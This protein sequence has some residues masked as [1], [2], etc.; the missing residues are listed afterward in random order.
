M[1]VIFL[2]SSTATFK[3][4]WMIK[5]IH[6]KKEVKNYLKLKKKI[7]IYCS[8]MSLKCIL[9]AYCINIYIFLQIYFVIVLSHSNKKHDKWTYHVF[10]ISFFRLAPFFYLKNN[11]KNDNLSLNCT[12]FNYHNCTSIIFS[13]TILWGTQIFLPKK[14]YKTKITPSKPSKP[15][16][17]PKKFEPSFSI[18][19]QMVPLIISK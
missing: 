11:P 14:H 3:K 5:M 7:I 8:C 12:F 4:I 9:F 15:P 17:L 1:M 2:F 10:V 13:G 18:W 6:T 19:H 16:L